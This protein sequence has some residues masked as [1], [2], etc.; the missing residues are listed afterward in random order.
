MDLINT[1]SRLQKYYESPVCLELDY[2]DGEVTGKILFTDTGDWP[3]PKI[4]FDSEKE[5]KQIVDDIVTLNS[6][7]FEEKY[8]ILSTW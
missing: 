7:A 2:D 5:F 3:P 8:C 4:T 6:E 1:L